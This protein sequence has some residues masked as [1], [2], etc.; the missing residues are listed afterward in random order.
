MQQIA[1]ATGL[2]MA[3]LV[4]ADAFAP[5]AAQEGMARARKVTSAR[6]MVLPMR[7]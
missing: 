2:D 6:D 7:F 1:D 3:L 5:V 4:A